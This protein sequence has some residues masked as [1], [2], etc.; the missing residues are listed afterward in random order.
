MEKYDRHESAAAQMSEREIDESLIACR[1]FMK[2]YYFSA[3]YA[4]SV[5]AYYD[6]VEEWLWWRNQYR[7]VIAE[8]AKRRIDEEYDSHQLR[9]QL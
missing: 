1:K 3:K 9:K 7:A 4:K 5:R 8:L 2:M 6:Y